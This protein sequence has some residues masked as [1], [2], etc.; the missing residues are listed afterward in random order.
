M[1]NILKAIVIGA[2]VLITCIV[3]GISFQI[4]RESKSISIASANN[5]NEFASELNE[6]DLT[7]Y[8]GLEVK[9]SDVLN[10]I[11]KQLGEY[12]SFEVASVSIN[13]IT[14]KSSNTYVNGLFLSDIVNFTND[15]Y[16]NPISKFSGKVIRNKNKVIVGLCFT[17][18]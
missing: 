1:E 10:F 9:G 2:G 18:M 7:R 11:K 5:L 17:Q 4:Y 6:S 3:I 8:D 16:I 13:V 14:S 15:K 12:E